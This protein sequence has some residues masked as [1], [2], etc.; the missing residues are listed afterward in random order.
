[1]GNK[2]CGSTPDDKFNTGPPNQ[3]EI[4]RNKQKDRK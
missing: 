4:K 1:M 3:E 2:L